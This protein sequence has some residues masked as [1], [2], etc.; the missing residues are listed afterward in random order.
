MIYK[1]P[2]VPLMCHI[3]KPID[4]NMKYVFLL[5]VSLLFLNCEEELYSTT[6]SEGELI[7]FGDP[8]YDGCGLVLEVDTI[9]YFTSPQKDT[10]INFTPEDSGR[11]DVIATY[12]ITGDERTIWGCTTIPAEITKIKRK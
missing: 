8:A 6:T 7:W 12:K 9:W 5:F 2:F 4:E 10:Y 3:G 1:L 11:I